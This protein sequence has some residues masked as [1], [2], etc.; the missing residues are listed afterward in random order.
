MTRTTSNHFKLR[1]RR[2]LDRKQL[3][4][5]SDR[6]RNSRISNWTR[7]SRA[8]KNSTPIRSNSSSNKE[9]FNRQPRGEWRTFIKSIFRITLTFRRSWITPVN[10]KGEMKI[11]NQYTSR[12]IQIQT[13]PIIN[14]SWAKL[15]QAIRT[16]HRIRRRFRSRILRILLV[17]PK[18]LIKWWSTTP[19]CTTTHPCLVNVRIISWRTGLWRP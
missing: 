11:F 16:N 13:K 9:D 8:A 19:K 5:S 3:R 1:S 7:N 10:T 2:R 17:S 14:G 15:F 4:G 6:S 12:Y 18:T